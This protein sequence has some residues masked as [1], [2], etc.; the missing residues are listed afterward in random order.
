MHLVAFISIDPVTK[1]KWC[2]VTFTNFWGSMHTDTPAL[3]ALLAPSTVP[4][5]GCCTSKVESLSSRGRTQRMIVSMR[6]HEWLATAMCPATSYLLSELTQL[7]LQ[8]LP[9]FPFFQLLCFLQD[10][11]A[12]WAIVLSLQSLCCA[13]AIGGCSFV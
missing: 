4:Q 8:C 13:V 12:H 3:H 1:Q 2:T 9:T 6:L 5:I 7:Q 11:Y 10:N